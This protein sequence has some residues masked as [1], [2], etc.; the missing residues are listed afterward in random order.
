MDGEK[1][2]FDFCKAAIL[3]AAEGRTHLS[4][5]PNF[6]WVYRGNVELNRFSGFK[7]A[8]IKPLKWL[9]KSVDGGDTQLKLSWMLVRLESSASF[10]LMS[11]LRP[12]AGAEGAYTKLDIV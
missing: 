8:E 3:G 9:A 1:L 6:G 12:P 2:R 10:E 4:L 11:E 7:C 5:T